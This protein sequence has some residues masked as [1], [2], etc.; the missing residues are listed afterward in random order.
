MTDQTQ[1]AVPSSLQRTLSLSIRLEDLQGPVQTKLRQL[2]RTAKLPGFRPGKV[3]V[4]MLEQMYGQQA[5]SEAINDAVS[6]AYGRALADSGLRPAGPPEIDMAEEPAGEGALGFVAKF[7]VYPEIA[8]PDLSAL[9]VQQ[10]QT[11]VTAEDLERTLDTLRSQRTEYVMVDRA[12]QADDQVRVDFEGTID[13]EAF[14]GGS[15]KDFRMMVAK[16]QMLPEFDNAVVGMAAGES[17]SF[18]LTFP[19][20][21][22][23]AQLAGKTCQF[24]ITVQEVLEARLPELNDD[25]AVAFGIEEG[26]LAKL[27]EEVEKNLRREVA[28]RAKAKTKQSVMDA[29]TSAATFDVPKALVQQESERLAE[30]M[31][32]DMRARGMKV[33]KAPFPAELFAAQAEKRVRLGL[34]V[35]DIVRQQNL[36]ATA[37]E[38][39]ALLLETAQ[40]YEDPEEFVEWTLSQSER[41]AEAQAVAIE[42]KVVAWVL[43]GAQVEILNTSVVDLLKPAQG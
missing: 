2:G 16:G 33:D 11:D 28:V 40:S 41:R 34:L 14:A 39:R 38:V 32:E 31:R 24:T 6:E 29:L 26:G 12:A 1:V 17:K 15:A 13:G 19:A 7:E 36:Q 30:Q 42:D 10:T 18:D 43:A 37:E 25:L 22:Q 8:M 35:G 9:T 23:A 5:Q 21:Y 20:D 3:P 27:R 4:K